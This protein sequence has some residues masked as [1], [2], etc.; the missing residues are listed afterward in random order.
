M[1][2]RSCL[3][4]AGKVTIADRDFLLATVDAEIAGGTASAEAQKR[5]AQALIDR[6]QSERQALQ[7]SVRTQHTDLFEQPAPVP[8]VAR[9][10]AQPKSKPVE[11]AATESQATAQKAADAA[12]E[13]EV[14]TP[15]PEALIALRK[16]E[17]VLKSLLE[18]LA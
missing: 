11:A 3:L 8:K 5:G 6:I 14:A 10:K 17:S 12:P 1:K 18:C 2:V 13:R 4:I 15:R 16:R 7:G 9:P